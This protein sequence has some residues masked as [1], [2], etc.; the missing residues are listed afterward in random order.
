M[1]FWEIM[2]ETRACSSKDTQQL[3]SKLH[4]ETASDLNV[5]RQQHYDQSKAIRLHLWG[6]QLKD[7]WN[8]WYKKIEAKSWQ[9]QNPPD[10]SM[11]MIWFS[12]STLQELI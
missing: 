3:S 6:A 10:Q 9:N 7:S 2:M 8:D 1:C 4:V 5:F 12:E 11:L